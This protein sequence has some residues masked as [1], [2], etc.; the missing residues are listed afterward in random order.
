MPAARSCGTFARPILKVL[1]LA[2]ALC[3]AVGRAEAE[4]SRTPEGVDFLNPFLSAGDYLDARGHPATATLRLSY[5][6][7]GT[8]AD[9]GKVDD[10]IVLTLADDW[11]MVEADDKVEVHDFRLG[12]RLAIDGD[13]G[14]FRSQNINAEVYFLVLER[15]NR[16]AMEAGFRAAG[17]DVGHFA[18]C[19]TDTQ[20]G[21]VLPDPVV[22]T[23]VIVQESADA[24]ELTCDGR[25]LASVQFADSGDAPA[26]L[27][28][29]LAFNL[30]IHPAIRS[31]LR[32]RG[33]VPSV[34]QSDFRSFDTEVK[35]VWTLTS[36]EAVVVPFPL[37][38]TMRNA[39]AENG[40]SN[41]P[42]GLVALAEAAANGTAGSGPPEAD[43]WL[44]HLEGLARS[45]PPAAALALIPT[46]HAF[47]EQVRRCRANREAPLCRLL[48]GI[49][50]LTATEPALRA[51]MQVAFLDLGEADAKEVILAAL[52]ATRDTPY[53]NDPNL[54]GI[55]GVA[56][57]RLDGSLEED[58]AKQGVES[59]PEILLKAALDAFPYDPEYWVSLA[60]RRLGGWDFE[61]AFLFLDTAMSLPMPQA[62]EAHPT[63]QEFASVMQRLRRDFP[64][65]YLED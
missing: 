50:G 54:L 42:S 43:A 39:T 18:G 15:Q 21:I 16:A 13:A 64:A 17:L 25:P 33:E 19:D 63:L 58:A 7:S 3:L 57:A 12:R 28:P 51:A 35:V 5:R 8:D 53:A 9:G 11:A 14:T 20:L 40:A 26:A 4:G 41:L 37:A 45:D 59:N 61:T 56:L 38:A 48:L 55:Y 27:W 60:I 22:E 47:P 30:Q 23:E 31:A 6:R 62:V 49:P 65:F 1:A 29:L 44:A 2:L 46:L 34:M 32:K 36:S 52:R 10:V 24:I